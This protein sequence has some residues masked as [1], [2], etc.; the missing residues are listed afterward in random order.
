MKSFISETRFS[1]FDFEVLFLNEDIY[2]LV[3]KF[4]LLQMACQAQM[5][6]SSAQDD[7]VVE[8]GYIFL[9]SLVLMRLRICYKYKVSV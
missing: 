6:K 4:F 9:H 2:L 8:L 1:K 5:E 3:E 7:I